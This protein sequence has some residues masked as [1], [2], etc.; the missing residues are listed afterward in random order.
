M[1]SKD[2]VYQK[3]AEISTLTIGSI[4]AV[5]LLLVR[6]KLTGSY[7]LLFLGWNL[8]LALIPFAI[9]LLLYKHPVIM[10]KPVYRTVISF[11]WLLFLPNAPYVLTD[12]V[13]LHLSSLKLVVFDTILIAFF[14]VT[15]F[16]SGIYSLRIFQEFYRI[17]YADGI[18]RFMTCAVALLCGYGVYL[19][20]FIRLNSWDVFTHPKTT[21][22]LIIR[23][24]EHPLAWLVTLIFGMLIFITT[25]RWG[26]RINK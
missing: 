17:F 1:K 13:H 24:L 18:V 14:A 21:F 8:F 16:L 12:F 3:Y 25:T 19:G 2:L 7:F 11:V 22:I 23:G 15:S 26:T 5:V 6:I 10:A 9:A 20:R 4:L